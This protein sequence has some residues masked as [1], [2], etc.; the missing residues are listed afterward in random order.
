[1][2]WGGRY[3]LWERDQVRE[4]EAAAFVKVV[5]GGLDGSVGMRLGV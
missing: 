3:W 5:Y 1:M 4:G 2:G